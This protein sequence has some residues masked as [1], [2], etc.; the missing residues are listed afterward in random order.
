MTFEIYTLTL[1]IANTNCY[2]I[3]D[4][5][6]GDCVMIDP[7]EEPETLLKAIAEHGWTL[8]LVLAT[9]GHFDHILAS[10]GVIDATGVPFYIHH[11]DLPLVERLSETGLRFVGH[12]WP[13][14]AKPTRLLT[15]ESEVIEVGN[16]KLHT[17]FTPGHA[18]GHIAYYWAEQHLV[19]SGDSLFKGTVG[20]TDIPGANHDI[21]M[22]SIF[23]KL[24]TLPNDTQILPGHGSSTS[25]GFERKTNPY[26]VG[27]ER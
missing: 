19:F 1:G 12:R 7:V 25:I 18:P 6:T 8:K 5:V 16:I 26:I 9:H 14:A 4:T 17:L 13:D 2:L 23:D 21:L 3:G 15:D 11:A 20:R 10:K 24:L 22:R 27:Y